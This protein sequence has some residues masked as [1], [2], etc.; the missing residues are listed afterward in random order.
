LLSLLIFIGIATKVFMLGEFGLGP[1]PTNFSNF[2]QQYPSWLYSAKEQGMIPSL[3]WGYT[4]G[5]AYQMKQVPGS[6]TLGGYDASRFEPNDMSFPFSEDDSRPLIVGLQSI[7]ATK[8]LSGNVSLLDTG[9]LSFIDSTVPE[10]WLPEAACTVFENAFGLQFNPQTNRY[11][12]NEATR[13]NLTA[14]S[15]NVTFIL[16]NDIAS[17]ETI[18]ITL[19]YKAFDLQLSCPIYNTTTNYFS[20]RR[21]TDPDQYSLGRTFLQEA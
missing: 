15:P 13:S 10:V 21:A 14:V 3:S 1:K 19:P 4:A 8:T 17:G 9:I 18:V 11:L 16:G 6:L 12:V 2:D 20:L 7:Q 5:A